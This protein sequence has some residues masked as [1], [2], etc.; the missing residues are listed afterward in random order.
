MLNLIKKNS[1]IR[2]AIPNH[3]SISTKLLIALVL[4]AT[5]PM[6][7]IAYNNLQ[8]ALNILTES[9]SYKLEAIAVS[10][11]SSL[12][13]LISSKRLT[14]NQIARNPKVIDFLVPNSAPR[15]SLYSKVQESLEVIL[16]SSSDY[17]A[18]FIMNE[19]GICRVSTNPNFI[20]Q[21]YSFR[22]YFK[23]AV[24]SQDTVPVDLLVG[25]TSGRPGLFFAH[26][27]RTDRGKILGVAVLKI[28]HYAVERVVNETQLNSYVQ[29]FLI[30]ENGIVIVHPND[31]F[32]YHSLDSL[33]ANV[34]QKLKAE[35]AYGLN[36]DRIKSLNLPELAQ[37]MVRTRKTGHT[38][39]YSSIEET[40]QMTGFTPLE[41]EPWVLGVN[42]P[43]DIF[44]SPMRALI[45]RNSYFVLLVG[46]TASIIALLLSRSLVKSIRILTRAGKAL[47]KGDFRPEMLAKTSR[48]QDDLGRLAFVFLQMAE[49]INNRERDLKSQV[50]NLQVEIDETK[51]EKQIAE[52]TGTE[53]FKDL[54]KR[55]KRL[56]GRINTGEHLEEDYFNKLHKKVKDQ[57]N[58]FFANLDRA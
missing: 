40:N 56:K 23:K 18:V 46:G 15:D 25:V 30:D 3:W 41:S 45:W 54:Q 42:T 21:N 4:A 11:A 14:I 35:N 20:G 22:N 19:K 12:D 38:N 43:R 55:A 37:S 6:S 50:Q 47:Q 2:R 8:L 17:D 31:S 33:P 7:L 34:Q 10:R 49:E 36:Y 58:R 26:P 57:K 16:R 5:I 39:Y 52:I 44:E 27:I 9:Q 32:L 48:S 13:Q 51:K 1:F 28:H 24:G 29:T 53:Y